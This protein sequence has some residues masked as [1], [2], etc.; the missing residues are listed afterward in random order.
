MSFMVMVMES[1][2]VEQCGPITELEAD[3]CKQQPNVLMPNKHSH[4][5]RFAGEEPPTLSSIFIT[6][7][8]L[9][10]SVAFVDTQHVLFP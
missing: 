2:G 10:T 1:C 6:T 3:R 8:L 9:F 4:L 7:F 5:Q